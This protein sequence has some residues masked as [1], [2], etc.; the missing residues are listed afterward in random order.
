MRLLFP[1][2]LLTA[3]GGATP[4]EAGEG[5]LF[6]DAEHLGEDA[7]D[8]IVAEEAAVDDQAGRRHPRGE[9]PQASRGRSR[10]GFRR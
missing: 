8:R 5:A 7:F 2:D 6:V 10:A 3:D 4:V 1:P 9:R